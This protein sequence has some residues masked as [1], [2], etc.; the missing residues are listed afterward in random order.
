[1]RATITLSFLV[2]A[3]FVAFSCQNEASEPP[4]AAETTPDDLQTAVVA[5][6]DALVAELSAERPADAAAYTARLR[7]YL[8]AHPAYYGSAAAML[9][10]AGRVTGCPYVYRTENGYD[11]LD[12]SAPSYNLE[13]QDWFT[14]PLE[15]NAG[16]WTAPYFDAGGGEIWMITRSVPIR[17]DEGVFAVITTD[18]PVDPPGKE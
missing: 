1:M 4:E 13:E 7:D 9:D 2:L 11:T 18:L 5:S 8:D 10:E 3:V 14:M 16:V 15:T 6:L 12:L 17:D